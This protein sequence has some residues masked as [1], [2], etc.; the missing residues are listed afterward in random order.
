MADSK[1]CAT[2]MELQSNKES[3]TIPEDTL[4]SQEIPYRQAI[5]SLMYLALG[6]RPDI[7]FAVSRLAQH[8]ES[9]LQSHWK[10]VK[11]VLRYIN[12]TKNL[13]LT[14]LGDTGGEII[15]YCDSDWAGCRQTRKSTEGYVFLFAGC[16]IS[17]KSKKQ[18]IIATSSCEAEYVSSCSAAKEAIWLSKLLFEIRNAD[19]AQKIPILMDNQGA[20]ASSK[21]QSIIRETST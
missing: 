17:W 3:S 5:G 12:R 16:A 4:A 13:D 14:F 10:A 15:G 20:I 9:P 11:R 8:C 21:N 19:H 1:P 6:T 7:A 2:P 18:S